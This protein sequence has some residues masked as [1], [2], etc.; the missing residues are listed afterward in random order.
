MRQVNSFLVAFSMYSRIPVPQP[1]WERSSMDYVMCY[2]PF[3]GTVLGALAWLCFQGGRLLGLSPLLLGAVLTA[4]P[5]W[6]SGGIHM[7]GYMDTRD[8]LAS[9]GDKE[10]KL[11]ILKDSH[12]GAFAVMG[13][14]LY[15]L[16]SFGAWCAVK[17]GQGLLCVCL[18][19]TVS[20]TLSGL[21]VLCFPKAKKS[22]SYVTMF[23]KR[24]SKGRAVLFLAL[25]LVLEGVLLLWLG[26]WRGGLSAAAAAAV[27]GWYYYMSRKQFG[28]ITGDLAGYFVQLCELAVLLAMA[29]TG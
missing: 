26:G 23:A 16:L 18:G 5:L 8:A 7:D 28:G 14:G 29:V 24:A 13:C 21:S 4:L 2:F 17:P 19:Y 12:T 22:G 9:C 3:V 20:R 6:I 27:F 1:D 11:A 25:L 10:K 15:L